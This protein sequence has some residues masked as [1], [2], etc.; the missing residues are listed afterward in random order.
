MAENEDPVPDQPAYEPIGGGMPGFDD[1][2]DAREN[3]ASLGGLQA[4]FLVRSALATALQAGRSPRFWWGTAAVLGVCWGTG[5]LLVLAV[6]TG[7]DL[8]PES[9]G[10]TYMLTAAALVLASC[11]LAVRW[12]VRSGS[13]APAAADGGGDDGGPLL[14]WA[15]A[16]AKGLMFAAAAGVFLLLFALWSGPSPAVAGVAFVLMA[17]E[18]VVFGGIGA[19]AVRWFEGHWGRILAWGVTGLFLVGNVAAAVALLPAVRSYEPVLVA[20]N[21][22]RD[23]F[24]Q[25]TSYR[26]SPEFRG[27]VEVYHTERIFW[28]A[29]SAPAEKSGAEMPLAMAGLATQF[30][31]AGILL[32][33]GHRGARRRSVAG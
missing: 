24:G 7:G 15:R 16:S 6:A 33:G 1:L 28:L 4:G 29:T 14:I 8:P 21:I 32:A 26:C 17:C 11:M 23:G 19:G 20:I 2:D 10:W 13:A 30:A 22:E 9:H 27:I 18:V 12:G 5:V 3:P 31:A 25:M